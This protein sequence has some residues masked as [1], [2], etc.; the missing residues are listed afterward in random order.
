[1][2]VLALCIVGG[3]ALAACNQASVPS[4]SATHTL[5]PQTQAGYSAQAGSLVRSDLTD[6]TT[7]TVI[8]ATGLLPNTA[9][10]ANYY[11]LGS[12]TGAGNCGSGGAVIGDS[13]TTSQI[14]N[15]PFATDAN[16]ALSIQGS[17]TTSG[18]AGAAYVDVYEASNL[19]TVPLCADLSTSN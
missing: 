10:A 16:G 14:G 4:T 19:A 17:E 12:V 15:Q 7:T 13:G 8:T 18:L 11:G 5:L 6:G 3:L 9:Y 1:M 2:K